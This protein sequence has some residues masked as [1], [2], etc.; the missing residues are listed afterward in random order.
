MNNKGF[1]LIELIAAISIMI[2]ISIVVTVNLNKT[3]KNK[4]DKR[5]QDFIRQ[6][7]DAACVYID[8]YEKKSVKDSCYPNCTVSVGT[9]ISEGLIPDNLKNPKTDE[10]IDSSLNVSV[11][12]S[13]VNGQL[14]VKTCNL[15][16]NDGD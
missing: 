15:N 2:I 1:T 4:D 11:T 3:V 14:G 10:V 13:T 7:N 6:V 16:I 12:W 8:L 5:Y 9:L